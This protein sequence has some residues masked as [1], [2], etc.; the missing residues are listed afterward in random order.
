MKTLFFDCRSGVC[1]DMILS[2]LLDMGLDLDCPAKTEL[3]ELVTAE[4]NAGAIAHMEGHEHHDHECCGH[5]A[6][7]HH[8]GYK[9]IL[10]II[11]KAPLTDGAKAMAKNIYRVI[12]E[13]EAKVHGTDLEHVHFH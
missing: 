2:G 5:E 7:H 3:R 4:L 8:T 13:A 1:S 12:A 6:G 9:Q 11:E 10:S